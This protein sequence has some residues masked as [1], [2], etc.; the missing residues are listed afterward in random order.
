MSAAGDMRPR[1]RPKAIARRPYRFETMID[2]ARYRSWF[3]GKDFTTDWTSGN[4]TVW[5]RVLSPLRGEPLQILEVGSWEGRSALFFLGFFPRASIVCIDTF[6]DSADMRAAN[7]TRAS[8]IEARFD[9]NLAPAGNRVEKIKDRSAAALERLAAQG[10]HFD[11]VYIDGDHSPEAVTADSERV[12]PLVRPGGV[13]I[14]DDYNWGRALLP[15]EQR[16]QS[17]ID[18]F[19]ATRQGAYR[20]LAKTYQIASERLQ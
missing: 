20:L 8:D 11:L 5:R 10:R 19:L 7:V 2:R 9:R 18:A 15:Y 4:F 6:Q 14:W 3:A 13:I 12:W 1:V 17:A 16:P